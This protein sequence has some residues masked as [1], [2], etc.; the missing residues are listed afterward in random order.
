[1]KTFRAMLKTE[2]KLS[3]RGMDMFNSQFPA[4]DP[5]NQT[6]KGSLTGIRCKQCACADY[7]IGCDCCS[8]YRYR[9]SVFSMGV[10]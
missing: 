3:L 5:G 7:N 2:L 4:S 8:L 10:N 1:M 6:A 9:H